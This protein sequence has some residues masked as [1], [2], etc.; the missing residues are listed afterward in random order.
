[1]NQTS[2][3][4][5]KIGGADRV[6][7]ISFRFLP[8][9]TPRPFLAKRVLDLILAAMFVAL[10]SPLLVVIA[11]L[12]K[13]DSHGPALF[14]QK[15]VGSRRKSRDGRVGWEIRT[16]DIY[17]FRTMVHHA[18]S[19]LHRT[20]VEAFVEGNLTGTEDDVAGFK[21]SDDP[22]ITRIGRLLRRSSLDELPQLLNVLRGEMSLVGPRPVPIYEVAGYQDRHYQRFSALPGITGLWQVRGRGRV[23]FEEAIRLDVEYTRRQSLWL[24]LE[25]LLL[26]IPAVLSGRGA[27]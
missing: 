16:F 1:M 6:E 3:K 5:L 22:R 2:L 17:K 13:L 26:T 9:A 14:V 18:D 24:D 12:V 25:L 4:P 21:L 19:A 10:L 20:Y 7:A 15:R 11:L 27:R 8:N 23:N